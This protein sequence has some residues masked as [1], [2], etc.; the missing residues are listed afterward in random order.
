MKLLSE[1]SPVTSRL[2]RLSEEPQRQRCSIATRHS[3]T[4][5]AIVRN[6][7]LSTLAPTPS[8]SLLPALSSFFPVKA[9][10]KPHRACNLCGDPVEGQDAGNSKFNFTCK[11]CAV[12]LLR[13]QR[14]PAMH[15]HPDVNFKLLTRSKTNGRKQR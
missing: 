15:Y 5:S 2:R 3:S 14:M 8:G 9:M 10:S 11:K 4:S 13:E 12:E 1:T 6:L 7:K